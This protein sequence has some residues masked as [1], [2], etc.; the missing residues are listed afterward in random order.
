MNRVAA[1][2][3]NFLKLCAKCAIVAVFLFL[4]YSAQIIFINYYF[5]Q[6]VS[7]GLDHCRAAGVVAERRST[8]S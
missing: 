2:S 1:L 4:I 8:G 3:L 6:G 5:I 7:A